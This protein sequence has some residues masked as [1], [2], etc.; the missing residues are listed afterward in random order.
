M[1]RTHE[2]KDLRIKFSNANYPAAGYQVTDTLPHR[3]N[4]NNVS[5]KN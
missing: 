3:I 1:V 5:W 4:R 2:V